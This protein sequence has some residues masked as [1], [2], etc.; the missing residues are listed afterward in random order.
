M[1]SKLPSRRGKGRGGKGGKQRTPQTCLRR[2][3]R[4]KG[5]EATSHS[6]KLVERNEKKQEEGREPVLSFQIDHSFR[7]KKSVSTHSNTFFSFNYKGK[8]RG[9]RP[10]PSPL[11][12]WGRE[13]GQK[14]SRLSSSLPS[15]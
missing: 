12:G 4:G 7:L 15:L 1:L 11:P 13:K 6:I 3:H 14:A 2:N 9:V 10:N 5:E 8:R